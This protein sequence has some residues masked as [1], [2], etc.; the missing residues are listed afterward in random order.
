MLMTAEQ[1]CTEA[2]RTGKIW[3]SGEMEIDV[4]TTPAEAY[5]AAVGIAEACGYLVDW[6]HGARSMIQISGGDIPGY[7]VLDWFRPDKRG[8]VK[9]ELW[10][11]ESSYL[12]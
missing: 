6:Y 2:K 8:I 3:L 12:E 9:V 5:H 7:V 11:S 10:F 4:N 1:I